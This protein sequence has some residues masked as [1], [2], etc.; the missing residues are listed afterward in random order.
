MGCGFSGVRVLSNQEHED[1][2]DWPV[3]SL[4]IITNVA[5]ASRNSTITTRPKGISVFCLRNEF[6]EE[7][8]SSGLPEDSTVCQVEDLDSAQHGVIRKKGAG[9]VCPRDGKRGAA[10]VDCL[11]GAENVGPANVLLSYCWSYTVLDIVTTLEEYCKAKEMDPKETY[12]WICCL[13][14]NQHRVYY[15]KKSTRGVNV[16]FDDFLRDVFINN[17]IGIGNIVAI[18]SP[19]DDPAYLSRAWCMFEMYTALATEGCRVE[20]AMRQSQKDAM[21]AS[22]DNFDKLLKAVS[23]AKIENSTTSKEQDRAN[24]LKLVRG[25]AGYHTVNN[26]IKDFLQKWIRG[27]SLEK[28]DG[29]RRRKEQEHLLSSDV[30]YSRLC[31]HVGKILFQ[32]GFHDDA[33]GHYNDGLAIEEKVYGRGHKDTAKAYHNIGAAL[34]AKKDYDGALKMYKRELSIYEK[35]VGKGHAST[36]SAQRNVG[37]V[38]QEKGAMDEAILYFNQS[39]SIQLDIHEEEHEDTATSYSLLGLAFFAKRDFDTAMH[40]LK[41]ALAIDEMVHGEDHPDTAMC[42]NNLGMVAQEIE[43]NSD[44]ANM[45]EKALSIREKVLGTNHPDTAQSYNNLGL[46]MHSKGDL[47]GSYK[48]LQKALAVYKKVVGIS[49]TNTATACNNI[50]AI[51]QD[52]GENKEALKYF[53]RALAIHRHILGEDHEDTGTCYDN[54]GMVLYHQ[55]DFEGAMQMLHKG[56]AIR[57]NALGEDHVDTAESYNNIGST[58]YAMNDLEGALAMT[59][60]ALTVEVKALGEGHPVTALSYNNI[61]RILYTMGDLDAALNIYMRSNKVCEKAY[62][63]DHHYTKLTRDAVMNLEKQIKKTPK[64]NIIE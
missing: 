42:Y 16:P 54:I 33:L 28:L 20:I 30:E 17:I 56:L 2:D 1:L 63:H 34:K 57:I 11:Q 13:C 48:M 59:E 35:T 46:A 52:M 14:N 41:K 37:L 36:A 32:M 8:Q 7:I 40:M 26:Q 15:E 10:Y 6:M 5:Q 50:G 31:Y 25:T 38:M 60:R 47:K 4:P 27:M 21:V 12:V 51:L 61:G 22:I 23:D 58:M 29:Y 53:R 9:I 45:H 39:L 19:W 44:A 49:H 43:D 18:L 55:D 62:G 64:Y 24:I 3:K